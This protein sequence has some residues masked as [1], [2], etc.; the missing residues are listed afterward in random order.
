MTK[1]KDL[2]FEEA[3]AALET[4]VRQ[5]EAGDLGL[6]DLLASFERGIGLLRSCEKKLNEA[7]GKIEVL[8]QKAMDASEAVTEKR[9]DPVD[10]V[11]LIEDSLFKNE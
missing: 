8:S 7:Q 1:T 9:V 3:L 11:E 2:S 5:M 4:T 6:D 10:N